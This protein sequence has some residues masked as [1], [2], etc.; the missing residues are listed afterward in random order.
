LVVFLVAAEISNSSAQEWVAHTFLVRKQVN[1]WLTAMMEAQIQAHAYVLGGDP[2][3]LT[4]YESALQ[5]SNKAAA[6]IRDLVIDNPS[7]SRTVQVAAEHARE[8]ASEFSALV[9]L[10]AAGQ[11]AAAVAR[12]SSARVQEPVGA[13]RRSAYQLRAEEDRLLE[14]RRAG[15][16]LR[17]RIDLAA[18]ILLML[19][20]LA[21]LRFAW[22]HERASAARLALLVTSARQRLAALSDIAAALSE[23]RTRRQVAEVIVARGMEIAGG[24]DVCTLYQVA[25]QATV[26]ELIGERGVAPAIR[27]KIR[28]VTESVGNPEMF[29]RLRAG[30]SVWAENEADYLVLFPG[31]AKMQVEG[32]RAK[33]FW[34]VPLR[35]EGQPVGLLG[36]GFYEPRTFDADER[37]F[38][39]TFTNQCAQALVRAARSER[40][41]EARQ[42]FTTTL[43]SIGDAVIATNA[44]G[45]VIF[46]NPIAENL[47]RWSES[48][49]RGRP[50]D[51]VFAIFSEKTRLPAESPVAKVL[52]E[53]KVV[54]LANHTVL[55]PRRGPEI[56]IDDSGAPIRDQ[57]GALSGV[58]LVFRDV[59][60]EKREHVRRD[61]LSRAGEALVSSLD[62]QSTLA[63]VT[64]LAVP[65]LADWCAVDVLDTG[66]A[67]RQIAVAHV[68]PM[69]M[70][71][72][73]EL[74]ELYPPDPNAPTGAPNVIR[75]G[76]SELYA[77]IP[78]ALLEAGA[79][80]AEH[81][82]LIRELRLESAMVVPLRAHG[83]T[84]GAMTFVHA[85]SG[86]RYN[87]DDLAFAED[88]AR[89]AA[90]AIENA[91]AL[92]AA[93]EA[94]AHQDALR[95]E[96][97]M[98]SRAKD[99]FLATVSHELRTPLNSILG[100]TVILR[101]RNQQQE[102][103]RGLAVIERNARS[104]AKLIED[105][106]DV[107]RIISG[108]LSLSL[109]PT[110][111][112]QA[113]RAAIET[114]T[115]AAE[116]KE[117]AIAFEETDEALTITADPDRLQQIVWN[118][119]SNAVKFTPKGGAVS[120]RSERKGSHVCISVAD[121]GEGVRPDVLP[122]IF[123]PFQQADASTTRRHGGLG[124]GLAI[125]KQLVTAH[126][127]TVSV[128]SAGLGKGATF[129]VDIPARSAVQA[130]DR[131]ARSTAQAEIP[132]AG[133][134][135]PPRLDG[136]R[137][138]V[139][140]DEADALAMLEEVLRE[141]GA[142]VVCA[143]SAAE[144][145]A[146]VSLLKPHVIVSDIGMPEQDGLTFMRNV[147]ALPPD[148]GG[149]I[150]AIALTA[151][152]RAEDAQRAL[153]AGFQK[154]VSK[155]AEPAHLASI[156]ADLGRRSQSG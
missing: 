117:I 50:L 73:R 25:D 138:L 131:A 3:A 77:E 91:L 28:R 116:A 11:R 144:A 15:A 32:K 125:V 153:A 9:S 55:R 107:S 8:S 27:D 39:E 154:H 92:R 136:L 150:P 132:A 2:A 72:A 38:V 139:V 128:A 106:L 129:T 142:E 4:A 71:F 94:R 83:R 44:E 118:L 41:D 56:P 90:M 121:T 37:A 112:G 1:D 95:A 81:L 152:A 10:A 22:K 62:Y 98:A 7:Q 57:E 123:E 137:V 156:V 29:G 143:S 34:G 102:V 20:T 47:T 101:K 122:I 16:K 63:T 114:V 24:A 46:M 119:L 110:N 75:T 51:E 23:A 141:G 78:P 42:W 89:R 35:V 53:G 151:Y 43:R 68:D 30:T 48:E 134:A 12:F 54:G 14:V 100:W 26:L 66:H 111:V 45:Q 18:E 140:D 120:L 65:A 69:K 85:E 126:G 97:E 135:A 33:A 115:P 104:Q 124:L 108:K 93:E 36:M 31:L 67:P 145:L 13:F 76:R 64:R 52:R 133:G 17:A 82:R 58:V 88:F 21:L 70:Q 79:R 40:E 127:G 155:P 148:A 146:R 59:T 105:V 147:R 74:T 6:Q 87:E 49:A 60:L 84:L 149:R 19:G 61:F 96:A 5:Q 113:V 109:S 80:D 86:R 130:V 99:D 103:D